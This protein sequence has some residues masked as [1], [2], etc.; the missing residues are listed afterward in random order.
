MWNSNMIEI[1]K[2]RQADFRRE[3]QRNRMVRIAERSEQDTDRA[4]QFFR[5]FIEHA[6]EWVGV[7]GNGKPAFEAAGKCE[8]LAC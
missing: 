3:A 1:A 8:Q 6:G 2:E 4:G 5:R 7:H